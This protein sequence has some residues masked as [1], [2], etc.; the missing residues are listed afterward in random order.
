MDRAKGRGGSSVARYTF[1]DLVRFNRLDPLSVLERA[2][3]AEN[4]QEMIIAIDETG[5]FAPQDHRFSFHVAAFVRGHQGLGERQ[6]RQF[7]EW[8]SQ[9]PSSCRTPLGEVKGAKLSHRQRRSFVDN[10]LTPDPQIGIVAFGA[11]PSDTPTTII[12][13]HKAIALAE[14]A[15]ASLECRKV[16]NAKMATLYYEMG[17]WIRKL[18]QQDF[19]KLLF[20][21]Q[22]IVGSFR[23][24]LPRSV[25]HEFD[26]ELVNLQFVIDRSFIK[27]GSP[28]AFWREFLR[29]QLVQRVKLDPLPVPDEWYR[30]R[31]PFVVAFDRGDALD[32]GE[33]FR[34]QAGFVRSNSRYEIQI[35]DVIASLYDRCFNK[36]EE[37]GEL[38]EQLQLLSWHSS[39]EKALPPP[40]VLQIL[41]PV[42]DFSTR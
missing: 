18:S 15:A 21:G 35:A 34:R 27:D 28:L 17:N 31:H 42:D 19:L 40:F 23:C 13:S 30:D 24:A 20:L 41:Q 25:V 6:R 4:P 1:A 29:N 14:I 9:I 39:A 5:S 3:L 2:Y 16:R 7:F 10:V 38:R 36:G 32:V 33:I 22:C 8:E 26:E 12:E 37:A 11:K